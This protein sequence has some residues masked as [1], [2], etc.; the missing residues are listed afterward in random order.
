MTQPTAQARANSAGAGSFR[1]LEEVVGQA[2]F[3]PLAADQPIAWGR[4]TVPCTAV[5]VA[6]FRDDGALLMVCPPAAP[7]AT[8]W[9][10]PHGKVPPAADPT[11][12]AEELLAQRTGVWP[13]TLTPFGLIDWGPTALQ[14]GWGWTACLGGPVG[15]I[16][17][18]P[19]GT[20][21]GR[22]FVP[23]VEAPT[24]TAGDCWG[25]LRRQTIAA[26]IAQFAGGCDYWLLQSGG[27]LHALA[28]DDSL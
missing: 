20:W 12:Y 2:Q 28:T 10:L 16:G 8:A 9:D 14:A 4:L 13:V 27:A 7:P 18:L 17:R 5:V 11:D 1:Y 26:A 23:P 25:A 21:G 22:A 15:V 19:P 6:C 3:R 24:R